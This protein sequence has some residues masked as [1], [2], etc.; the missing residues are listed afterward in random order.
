LSVMAS[1]GILR[2]LGAWKRT[3]TGNTNLGGKLHRSQL[4]G[5]LNR[6]D[7][8]RDK[9][10]VPQTIRFSSSVYRLKP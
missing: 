2:A 3:R 7:Y 9:P 1:V 5:Q 10:L 8:E 6:S 4:A